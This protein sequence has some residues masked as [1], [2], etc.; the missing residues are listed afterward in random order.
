MQ[1]VVLPIK[2]SAPDK[3]IG[4]LKTAYCRKFI[5]DHS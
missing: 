2:D 3:G 1:Q 5:S 4:E